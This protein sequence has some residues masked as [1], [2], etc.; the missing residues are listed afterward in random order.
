MVKASASGAA[1]PVKVIV[2]RRAVELVGTPRVVDGVMSC[3]CARASPGALSLRVDSRS[4]TI[5]VPAGLKLRRCSIQVTTGPL[6]RLSLRLKPSK[7]TASCS[8][9]SPC[10]GSCSSRRSQPARSDAPGGERRAHAVERELRRRR[11]SASGSNQRSSATSSSG[12]GSPETS[13]HS[14]NALIV[15]SPRVAVDVGHRERRAG[16]PRSRRP[17]PRAARAART[18]RATRPAA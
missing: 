17:P 13:R 3:A 16:R 10:A 8:R 11:G 12:C 1:V 5:T 14:K 4:Q 7:A 6:V 18:P 9:R 15:A 2:R